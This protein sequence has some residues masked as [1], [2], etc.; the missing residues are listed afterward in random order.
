MALILV[1]IAVG[2]FSTLRET[3]RAQ[4]RFNDVR[5]VSN[6][7]LFE[8]HDAIQVLPGSTPAR[9]LLLSRALR[10]LDKLAAEAGNDIALQKQ[11]AAGY[12]RLGDVQGSTGNSNLGMTS[13]AQ[14]SY[15]KALA[16]R[17]SIAAAVPDD[18]GVQRDLASDYDLVGSSLEEQGRGKE[19]QTHLNAAFQLRLDLVDRYPEDLAQ[20]YFSQGLTQVSGANF[21][22]ARNEFKRAK[23][24]WDRTAAT[25][26]RGFRRATSIVHKRIG[27][28]LVRLDRLDEAQPEYETALAIDWN[29]LAEAPADTEI[30]LDMSYA[31]SDLAL[32]WLRRDQFAK[33]LDYT[34]QMRAIREEVVN[35][36]PRKERARSAMA[37]AYTRVGTILWRTGAR[38]E[39]AE[40]A[41]IAELLSELGALT[42]PW[43]D[44][45]KPAAASP[46]LSNS[47]TRF[48]RPAAAERECRAVGNLPS[49]PD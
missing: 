24:L 31:L 25:D 18:V 20:S 6:S 33:A 15:D 43:G 23:S 2:I 11:L 21:E 26:P 38:A 1:S 14:I 35:A 22:G 3:K 32:I 37:G 4:A 45:P 28:I 10:F 7:V 40:Q 46:K 42:R 19:G 12:V 5:E 49:G 44:R 27:G 16:L 29:R 48:R 8:I 30:K 36:D 47:S 34:Q 41:Q 13:A 17:K 9:E 39:V